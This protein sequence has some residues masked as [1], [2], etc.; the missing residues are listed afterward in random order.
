LFYIIDIIE[1]RT[2]SR[3]IAQLGGIA[4]VA[5]KLATLFVV[6][7]LGSVALPLTNGFVGE[8]L[9][10]TSLFMYKPLFAAIA[11]LSVILGAVYMLRMYKNVML[12]E[13]NSR[14]AHFKDLDRIELA[15]LLF[16]ALMVI[17]LGV[18]P[19]P[20]LS[21]ASPEVVLLLK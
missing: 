13:I 11:G 21:L 3:E 4:N 12:G 16:V 20:L 6:I 18:Y 8:F 7:M 10:L 5:P 15:G 14:T 9:L 19:Q 2:Q 1:R 17:G